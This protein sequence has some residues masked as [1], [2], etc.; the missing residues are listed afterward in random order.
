MSSNR[1]CRA[2]DGVEKPTRRGRPS[3]EVERHRTTTTYLIPSFPEL[4]KRGVC[5]H[6]FCSMLHGIRK[7]CSV[8][9]VVLLALTL[10]LV[11]A[12]VL[13]LALI[14]ITKKC[15]IRP[16]PP[17]RGERRMFSH[18][19]MCVA[20]RY[21]K[22][23]ESALYTQR[24]APFYRGLNSNSAHFE[25]G[26]LV[27]VLVLVP[28]PKK[29]VLGLVFVQVPILVHSTI[30]SASTSAGATTCTLTGTGVGAGASIINSVTMGSAVPSKISKT[31]QIC[32]N[33]QHQNRSS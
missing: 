23:E 12:R 26:E 16:F 22:V 2:T 33:T 9:L 7:E 10:A 18:V 8:L 30:T 1:R 24:F 32:K 27:L 5:F 11:L 20:V 6:I 25:C 17:I 21:A 13:I 4:D 14:L 19:F 29:M 31:Q 15:L 3:F 28:I